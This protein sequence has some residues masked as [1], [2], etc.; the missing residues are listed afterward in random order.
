MSAKELQDSKP[1]Y[2][3]L[4]SPTARAVQIAGASMFHRP[5]KLI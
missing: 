4:K 3:S 5:Q 1:L 2:R